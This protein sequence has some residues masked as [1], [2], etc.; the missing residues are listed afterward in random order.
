MHTT[1][2]DETLTAVCRQVGIGILAA[3][4]AIRTGPAV[5]ARRVVARVLHDDA[6]WTIR[7]IALALNRNERTVERMLKATS[8]P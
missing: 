1:N 8:L 7:R 3:K 2:D 4:G 5:N 6:G